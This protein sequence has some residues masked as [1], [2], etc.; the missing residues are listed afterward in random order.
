MVT[1]KNAFKELSKVNPFFERLY[2]LS[3]LEE[4]SEDILGKSIS[5]H[6]KFIDYKDGTLYVECNDY[7][8]ATEIKKLARQIKKRLFETLQLDI[9]NIITQV[10]QVNTSQNH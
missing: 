3:I 9:K 1:L 6:L 8:W 10:N 2:V 4:K 7:I 5:K